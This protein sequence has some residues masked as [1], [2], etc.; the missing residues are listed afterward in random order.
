MICDGCVRL[1]T[2]FTKTRTARGWCVRG[3]KHRRPAAS[4]RPECNGTETQPWLAAPFAH[5][6]QQAS[7]LPGA[8]RHKHSRPVDP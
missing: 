2:D 3:M 8:G 6:R 7:E 1:S 5:A 4:A